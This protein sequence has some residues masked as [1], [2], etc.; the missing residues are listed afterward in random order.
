MYREFYSALDST[1]LPIAAMLFFFV[2]F[3]LVLVRLFVLRRRRDYDALAA[4]PL[5]DAEAV[6]SPAVSNPSAR[7]VQ[8]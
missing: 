1:T 5:D 6:R 7:E 3:L 8:S 2:V 4:L